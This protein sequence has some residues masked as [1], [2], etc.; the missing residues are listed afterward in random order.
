MQLLVLRL[1]LPPPARRFLVALISAS[2]SAFSSLF[3]SSEPDA[4]SSVSLVSLYGDPAVIGTVG[5]FYM[6]LPFCDGFDTIVKVAD[7]SF[8]GL[9]LTFGAGREAVYKL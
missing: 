2:F 3:S 1:L 7:G 8:E 5:Y 9:F 4:R 6:F